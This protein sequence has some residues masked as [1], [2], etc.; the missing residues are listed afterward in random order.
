MSTPRRARDADGRNRRTGSALP[1][2][3]AGGSSSYP[4]TAL[5]A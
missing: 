5:V 2:S 1:L 3:V 4:K